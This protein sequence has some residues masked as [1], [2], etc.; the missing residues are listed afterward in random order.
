M[1]AA[2]INLSRHVRNNMRLYKITEQDI[3]GAI[4]TPDERS[5]ES[6]RLIGLKRFPGKYS[7][8]PLKV[9][10]RKTGPAITVI[11]AYPLKRKHWG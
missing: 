1:P 5:E 9:V 3:I 2:S 6:G 4:D 11:T 7:G 10:Y 8:C